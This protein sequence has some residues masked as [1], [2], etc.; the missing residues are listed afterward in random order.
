LLICDTFNMA[1]PVTER[2]KEQHWSMIRFMQSDCVE[3]NEI[4]GIV[5]VQYGDKRK[6]QRQVYE[7]VWKDSKE[8]ERVLLRVLDGSR[9]KPV[10]KLRSL[11]IT[12][13]GTT[14][15]S[16]L[17]KSRLKWASVIERSGRIMG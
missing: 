14:E 10:S 12:I 16:V 4:Y 1:A 5:T 7:S 3:S 6:S 17:M 13:S 2:T 15:V 8:A 11:S 9:K